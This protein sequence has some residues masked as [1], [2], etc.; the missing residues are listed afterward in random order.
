MPRVNWS[1]RFDVGKLYTI[2]NQIVVFPANH[3]YPSTPA[4]A[5]WVDKGTVFIF[6]GHNYGTEENPQAVKLIFGDRIVKAYM[7]AFPY[8]KRINSGAELSDI[9]S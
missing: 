6:L 8:F 9:L 2:S 1:K 4:H 3:S 7:S 5:R